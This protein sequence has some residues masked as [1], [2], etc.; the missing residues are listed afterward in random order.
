MTKTKVAAV[1]LALIAP[2]IAWFLVSNQARDQPP[3]DTGTARGQIEEVNSASLQHAPENPSLIGADEGVDRVAQEG[4]QVD[5]ESKNL[6]PGPEQAAAWRMLAFFAD[7]GD[8]TLPESPLLT[9]RQWSD[10]L[11][12]SAKESNRIGPLLGRRASLL[13]AVSRQRF[14]AGALEEIPVASGEM[15][16][17]ELQAAIKMSEPQSRRQLV[18]QHFEGGKAF[19]C[20]VN[21]GEQPAIDS[22]S[23]K[24]SDHGALVADAVMRIMSNGR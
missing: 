13:E 16:V 19:V 15:D 24:I 7:L 18:S 6:P 21:P 22:L 1:T 23:S 8:K 20:R 17:S 9:P 11:E 2:G 12:L 14:A 4:A 10:I 3:A 5:P